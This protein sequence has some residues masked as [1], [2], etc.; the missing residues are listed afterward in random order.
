MDIYV[1]D[2]HNDTIKP[3]KNS[4][5]ESVVDSATHK[6][7]I[8]DKTLRLFI[9]PQVRKITPKSCQICGCELFIIPKDIQIDLNIPRT[10]LV[11]HLKH[12]YVG[13]HTHKSAY[14]N[15][16]AAHYKYNVFPYGECLHAT[17]K[18]ASQ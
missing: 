17:I 10:N 5:L 18:D 9:P 11:T 4:G 6:V 8:S 14:I 13:R 12:N 2:L 16:S 3:S 1:R 15:T 7:L